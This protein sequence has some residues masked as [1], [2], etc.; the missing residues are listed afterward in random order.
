MADD[1]CPI[2]IPIGVGAMQ[3]NSQYARPGFGTSAGALP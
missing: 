3:P 1:M 2:D